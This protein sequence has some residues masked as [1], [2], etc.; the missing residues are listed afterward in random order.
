MNTLAERIQAAMSDSG[1]KQAD[2]ASACGVKA[3]SISQLLNGDTKTMAATTAY[4]IASATG[5]D[6]GWLIHGRGPMR[7]AYKRAP[8]VFDGA[9]E[10]A[11][12]K[13][14]LS[15]PRFNVAA[16]MGSG[17]YIEPEQ[18]IVQHLAVNVAA[19]RRLVSF[20]SPVKLSFITGQGDS[21]EPTY[22]DGDAL[23]VDTG[24]REH[25]TDAVY[26][27]TLNGRLYVKTLQRRPDGTLLMISDNKKYDAY[28]IKPSDEAIIQGRVLL[29]WN[30]RRL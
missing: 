30:A 25:T 20:T 15:V 17:S 29:A 8:E 9:M 3:A 18:E 22:R 7:P 6:I 2:L 26:V 4:G 27:L 23:L 12:A 1:L 24:V 14:A 5:V 21:M 28:V 10:L 19:L 13:G 11:Q 16:S